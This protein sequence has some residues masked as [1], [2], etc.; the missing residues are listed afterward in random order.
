[1]AQPRPVALP[2]AERTVGQLVAESVRFYGD[3]FWPSLTLGIGPAVAAA[4]GAHL[5][6][7]ATLIVLPTA[8]GAL[9]S[10]TY[11][12]ACV[13][14]LKSS[15]SRS[16][17]VGAWLVGWLVFAPVAPLIRF[18]YVLPGIAW[19]AAFA[20]LVPVLVAEQ[21]P[22]RASVRRALTLVRADWIHEVGSLLTLAVLAV[23]TQG[24]IAFT[25]RGFA[26]TAVSVAYF[27]AA[28]VVSPLLFI[29]SALLYVDQSARVK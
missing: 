11:V 20:L 4:L 28:A 27:L 23:L 10:A 14:V 21:L 29:G 8:F 26:D 1:M 22:V 19:L 25:L 24:V 12:Y 2:P 16:R 15:P 3:N 17:L 18:T 9:L 7:R 6:Q 13:L 5:S